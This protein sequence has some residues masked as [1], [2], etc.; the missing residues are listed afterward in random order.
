MSKK[1]LYLSPK[2]IHN[3]NERS[4]GIVRVLSKKYI[5]YPLVIDVNERSTIRRLI[6]MLI[7]LPRIYFHGIRY[8]YFSKTDIIFCE[9]IESGFIGATLSIITGRPC[10]WDVHRNTLNLCI[11]LKKSNTYEKIY[12]NT[13][14]ILWRFVK[15]V[16]VISDSEKKAYAR[17]GIDDSKINVIPIS[18]DFNLIKNVDVDKTRLK[19]KL[20]LNPNKK[21]LLFFGLLDY[22][23]N[24]N[25]VQWINSDLAPAIYKQFKENV[26]ILI[27]GKGKVCK[28]EHHA[29]VTFLGFKQNLYEYISASD[30]VIVPIW[31]GEG[32]Q[33]K[34]ID[35]MMCAKLT[36]VNTISSI[37]IPE[38][39]DGYNTIIAQDK[40]EFIQKTLNAI[41]NIDNL[42]EI[43]INA[44]KMID[45][46]YNWDRWKD[47][48]FEIIEK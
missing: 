1:I 35:S 5:V 46:H 19:N 36:I 16:L 20:G 22:Q 10:I 11:E 25:A 23:P 28:E 44:K 15:K 6:K 4:S 24:K 13:E 14:K 31:M 47:N 37:G 41:K 26:E 3:T 42:R 33:T 48:L 34:L 39:L 18:A 29:I 40:D 27:I 12:F 45:V 9:L 32:Q 8:I 17:Q 43:E 7:N 21:R 38:L 30:I 2:P